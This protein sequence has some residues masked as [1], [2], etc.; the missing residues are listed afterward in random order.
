MTRNHFIFSDMLEI[1]TAYDDSEQQALY[2]LEYRNGRAL[3]DRGSNISL[4][5]FHHLREECIRGYLDGVRDE[6]LFQRAERRNEEL[7]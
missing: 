1:P 2:A 4:D 3:V 6:L 5:Y 7:Q